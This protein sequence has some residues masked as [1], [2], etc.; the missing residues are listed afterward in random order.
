MALKLRLYIAEHTFEAVAAIGQVQS[1]LQKHGS[2][3]SLEVLDVH[4]NRELS[5]QD[6]VPFTPMLLRLSP[7]PVLRIGMP[8]SNLA[9]LETALLGNFGPMVSRVPVVEK[10]AA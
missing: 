8:S 5:L 3:Y 7:G 2:T 6:E 1:F 4:Q 9:E 10:S